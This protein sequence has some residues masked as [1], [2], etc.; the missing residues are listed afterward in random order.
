MKKTVLISMICFML[1][2]EPVAVYAVD[3]VSTTVSVI[4]GTLGA[5]GLAAIGASGPIAAAAI[6]VTV[7]VMAGLKLDSHISQKSA[8]AGMTKS[9][10]VKQQIQNYCTA[11]GQT[12]GSWGKNL[13]AGVRIGQQGFIY[14]QR[15][16]AA[17]L[18]DFFNWND[19]NNRIL[20]SSQAL[21]F[22]V[23]V[24]GQLYNKSYVVQNG[25]ELKDKMIFDTNI[26]TAKVCLYFKPNSSS[27]LNNIILVIFAAAPFTITRT[28]YSHDEEYTQRISIT[29]RRNGYYYYSY[30]TFTY[31]EQT[32]ASGGVVGSDFS[33]INV[34][35]YRSYSQSTLARNAYLDSLDGTFEVV[36]SDKDFITSENPWEQVK[37]DI[38]PAEG[39][40]VKVDPH[41]L[42]AIADAYPVKG[43]DLTVALGDYLDALR[44]AWDGTIAD[45]IPA[46]DTATGEEVAIPIP[47]DLT[48]AIPK[49]TTIDQVA[50]D[51]IDD[52]TTVPAIDDTVPP[53]P[54]D[55]VGGLTVGLDDIFPFCLPFDI[56]H[57]LQK[58]SAAPETPVVDIE[59]PSAIVGTSVPLHIDLSQ[60]DGVA[61]VARKMELVAYVV[62]LAIVTR[63]TVLRG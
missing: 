33:D 2:F 32:L 1:A 43:K 19:V 18:E 21:P 60:F 8:N 24:Q 35:N 48:E 7:A 39:E 52:T 56:Y 41:A 46:V 31:P 62:G 11:T 44:K 30:G 45:T 63:K 5:E 59:F 16:S 34:L 53:D 61:S 37:A 54:D 55:T 12:L 4:G 15:D 49:D 40:E 23:S 10:Y 20:D 25:D 13:L 6:G 57:I 28:Y 17:L 14:L 51:T 58:F 22:D 9:A 26:D 38:Q 42:G 50:E 3:P 47:Q 29:S 36:Q 27:N